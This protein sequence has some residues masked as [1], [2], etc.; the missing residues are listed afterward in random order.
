M[1]EA[2]S[3]MH[4]LEIMRQDR[5]GGQGRAFHLRLRQGANSRGKLDVVII[6]F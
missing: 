5:E 6:G 2:Q 4:V 3:Y 1:T